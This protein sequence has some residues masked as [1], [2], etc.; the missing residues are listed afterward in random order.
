MANLLRDH[1]MNKKILLGAAIAVASMQASAVP[2][3]PT[4]ARAMAMGG[5]GVSSA[6]VASTVQFNPALLA[7]TREDDHFGLTLPSLGF[8]LAD[9]NGFIEEVEDFDEE[10]LNANPGSGDTNVDLL[11]R[12]LSDSTGQNGLGRLADA[13]T[14]LDTA[15]SGTDY[16]NAQS[17]LAAAVT[18]L[19]G[20]LFSS[21]NTITPDLVLHSNAVADDLDDLNNKALRLNMGGNIALAVPS[22]K[23][24]LALSAGGQAVFSGQVI[25]S[26]EDT[27][28]LRNY[29]AATA[30][31]LL[32]VQALQIALGNVDDVTPTLG[33]IQAVNDAQGE[34]EGFDYG[35]NQDNN[36]NP[37]QEGSTPIFTDGVLVANDAALNSQVQMV[38]VAIADLGLTASRV[39]NIKGHDISFGITP[40]LQKVT[41]FDYTQ[42]LDGKDENGNEVVFESDSITD[43]TEDYTAFNIDLGAAYQ[44]GSEDQF[45]AG[46]VIKNL[47]ANDF[48]SAPYV[49]SG[50]TEGTIVSVNPMVRAGVSHKTDWTK[51]AFDLDLTENDPV[52]FEDPTQYASI[53]AEFNVFRTLQLRAGYRMNL[54][55]SG[56][57]V[58]T[59]GFGLSPFAIRMDLG[60][61]ANADDPEKEAGVAFEFGV[62]F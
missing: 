60:V 21:D 1:I 53:G 25:V 22:K 26:S 58:V 54:A 7:N 13:L 11:E 16:N 37:G 8:S 55:G 10:S 14:A 17:E 3:A 33:Q 49:T 34:L 52:A 19:D 46:V 36:A 35:G 30:A 12:T 38:G 41:I 59:A 5:T 15:A 43:S 24:S 50:G 18:Y 2:F 6:E 42:D 51:V 28:I 44:F 62:E 57:D 23:F 40:K 39:F 56:Q 31:Y 47:L 20:R 4:D 9:D 27:D 48:E 32:K 29:S 45:Q 61:M